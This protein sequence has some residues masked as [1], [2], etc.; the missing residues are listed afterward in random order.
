MVKV[1]KSFFTVVMSILLIVFMYMLCACKSKEF[2]VTF[3]VLG[4]T[5]TV[6]V[7]DGKVEFPSDPEK[8]YYQ[9]R[10][11]YKTDTFLEGS[12]FTKDTEVKENLTVYAYFAPIYVGIS[13][14]GSKTIDI[15]LED[16]KTKTEEYKSDASSKNLTFDGWYIDQGYTTKYSS[17]DADNLYARYMAEVV[18][19]NGYEVVYKTLVQT[20]TSVSRP[21]DSLIVKNYMDSEDISFETEDGN[22]YDFNSIIQAN[23]KINVKWKSP[24]LIYKKI[25][26]TTNYAAIGFESEHASEVTQFPCL[27]IL[28]KNVNIKD[29]AGNRLNANVV[30]LDADGISFD[31][32]RFNSCIEGAKK[33]IF[34]EGIERISS[35]QGNV[36][37]IVE[38]IVFPKS[39]K[40]LEKSIWYFDNLK[41]IEL[42]SNV[43]VIID[44]FWKHFM[45]YTN[46]L[47]RGKYEYD[48]DIVI[49]SSVKSLALV[50]LNVV[51]S[52]DS[53][54][55]IEDNQIYKLDNG[56][57]SLV[58]I[59]QDSVSDGKLYIKEGVEKIH[60]GILNKLEF[61][62]L[63]LPSTISGV[64][65]TAP[66]TDYDMIYDGKYLTDHEYIT[67]PSSSKMHTDA[68]TILDNL[69]SISYVIF[70]T[71]SYP[72][73]SNELF[74][75]EVN[76]NILTYDRMDETKLVFTA[77]VL[78]G[79]INLNIDYSN[80]MI[81]DSKNSVVLTIP[82]NTV[83][84]EYELLDEIGITSEALGIKIKVTSITQF[85]V[86]Y[87]FGQKDCNQ[88]ISIVYEYDV[89]G[90]TYEENTD[91]K[92]TVTGFDQTTAQELENGTY[93]VIIPDV[94]NDIE[95]T[96]ISENAFKDNNRISKVYIGKYVKVIGSQAFM[97]TSN[98]EYLS[99][100][101]GSLETIE[102]SA[103][104][105]LGCI[106]EDGKWNRNPEMPKFKFTNF[107]GRTAY[108]YIP[109][110]KLKTVK[111]YAFKSMAISTFM[112]VKGEES[113]TLAEF[114]YGE[115]V[116]NGSAVIGEFYYLV[117]V[118][119][120]IIALARYKDIEQV[121]RISCIDTSKS[122]MVN[123]W[124]VEVVATV[125]GEK[126][127]NTFSVGF[128]LRTFASFMGESS[129]LNVLRFELMEG[130]VYYRDSVCF[131]IVSKVHKNAFTDMGIFSNKGYAT[132]EYYNRDG[133][134]WITKEDIVEQNSLIFEDGWW[135]GI[136]NS[137][138]TAVLE[139]KVEG[140]TSL[141][142]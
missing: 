23:T 44:C 82:T 12:E 73:Q 42:P 109:L 88:Y 69:E 21:E 60:V 52:N 106:Y 35:L 45:D 20:E 91:L 80:S 95:I 31:S 74:K 76:N 129:D 89:L 86:D 46:G 65:Y 29:T 26:G 50:P 19:D 116:M 49:P 11:W 134:I 120:D 62:Y 13:V 8:E 18:F 51:F 33:I 98:L 27:S 105:N 87:V 126:S 30:A 16:L 2:T 64:L 10:G 15:K 22:E 110:S 59:M 70:N 124:D 71:S 55:Y 118:N 75:G 78:E 102:Q 99:I 123:M 53:N 140:S 24:Y 83:L 34:A 40:I 79:N 115:D 133:D 142:V 17:Q 93:L 111:P 56:S 54:Y 4:K 127:D 7:I 6:E 85:G 132:I 119:S 121:E 77:Q 103:F 100:T 1:K 131:G 84:D 41:S 57:V 68:Y 141:L 90:F 58:S 122:V 48:F 25:E 108:V 61:D 92:Y 136:K 117:D 37:T 81:D 125:S 14:N 128:S 114:N 43:E 135:E 94:L 96:E 32:Y 101:P 104:E 66:N 97:N 112:P 113:R 72:F 138:N 36:A 38:E 5:Q 139:D 9:F 137:E 130:S 3:N 67:S 28:S 107:T 47:Y 39:L 63:Y